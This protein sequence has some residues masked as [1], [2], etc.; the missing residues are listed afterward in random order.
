MKQILDSTYFWGNLQ[1]QF[2]SAKSSNMDG[3]ADRVASGS[4]RTEIDQFIAKYE[5]EA[6]EYVL[7]REMT[8]NL[9]EALEYVPEEPEEDI[10]PDG[11]N[12]VVDDDLAQEPPIDIEAP[13]E[14]EPEE[15]P[16]P[17][18]PVEEEEPIEGEEPVEGEE[19]EEEEEPEVYP[20]PKWFWL[21]DVIYD[22]D[23]K[24][25]F[26][27]NYVW[28]KHNRFTSVKQTARATIE[29]KVTNASVVSNTIN[30]V[31]VWNEFVDLAHR[32][33]WAIRHNEAFN[34]VYNL[35]L[36]RKINEFGI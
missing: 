15:L 14:P 29:K 24:S 19:P 2:L 30:E 10:L 33:Q 25:S 18:P 22:T 36:V 7:G 9:I 20:D 35:P 17:E 27:A 6:L 12:V 26:V 3:L 32:V 5:K 28:F 21:R 23:A 16:T 31:D 34:E 8:A 13:N 1:I 4:K 11:D